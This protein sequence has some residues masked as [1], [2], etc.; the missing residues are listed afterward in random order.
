[1]ISKKAAKAINEQITKEFYSAYLYLSMSA[2]C[3]YAGLK[4]FANWSRVQYSEELGHGM[5]FIEYLNDQ[6]ARV[7]LA[8][9]RQPPVDF[10]SPLGLFELSLKHEQFVTR[11][12]HDL[13]DLAIKE[14]D[15]ATQNMLKWFVDEQVEEE[16]NAQAIIGML[17]HGGQTGVALFMVDK[18]LGQRKAA[19]E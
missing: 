1:V 18:E 11:S 3:E 15:Y 5:K 4:G 16:A 12:I 14:K 6:G 7:E 13:V 9:I 17:K 2:H 10:K 19:G 8:A